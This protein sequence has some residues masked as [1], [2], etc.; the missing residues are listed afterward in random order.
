MRDS[1]YR[2]VPALGGPTSSTDPQRMFPDEY[3]N[4]NVPNGASLSKKVL[5][6]RVKRLRSELALLKEIKEDGEARLKAQE[7]DFD[8]R[9]REIQAQKEENERQLQMND[10]ALSDAALGVRTRD[11]QIINLGGKI[12]RGRMAMQQLHKDKHQVVDRAKREAREEMYAER[13]Q[14]QQKMKQQPSQGMQIKSIGHGSGGA[15]PHF[16][17]ASTGGG[18]GANPVRVF[19]AHGGGRAGK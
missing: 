8:K 15:G 12:C 18:M 11:R 6:E 2:G 19:K 13:Q 10:K 3:D 5:L 7:L 17:R 1:H 14:Q 16:T 4:F 9:N